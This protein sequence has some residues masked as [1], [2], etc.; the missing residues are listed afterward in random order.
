MTLPGSVS[1][2][3]T[4]SRA[5]LRGANP[6]AAATDWHSA[7]AALISAAPPSVATISP[8]VPRS[9]QF[10]PAIALIITNF[11]HI[12]RRMFSLAG[13]LTGVPAKAASITRA[14]SP[15]APPRSPKAM[16]ERRLWWRMLPSGRRLAPTYATPPNTRSGPNAASSRSRWTRPLSSGNTALV[17]MLGGQQDDIVGPADPVGGRDS[18]RHAKIAERARDR[19]A[20]LG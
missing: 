9:R 19:E 12:S 7:S 17:V 3:A 15:I 20:V 13:A 11:S 6:D 8:T 16:P 5:W 4:R 2:A 1:I 10:I 14:I 18:D